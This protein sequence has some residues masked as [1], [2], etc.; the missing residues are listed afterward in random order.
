M[1]D[2]QRIAL[3]ETRTQGNDGSPLQLIR[4]QFS[5][6]LGSAILELTQNGDIISYEEYYPYG[7]TSYQ[8]VTSQIQAPRKRYR[9]TGMERD[10][11]TGFNYHGAR[12]YVLWLGR[13]ASADPA[14]LVDGVN[15]FRYARVNPIRL[16]DQ[17][18]EKPYDPGSPPDASK[19]EIEYW[20]ETARV[21]RATT[22]KN[23]DDY[24]ANS[25]DQVKYE[26]WVGGVYDY[27]SDEAQVARKQ[28]KIQEKLD[29]ADDYA[30]QAIKRASEKIDKADSPQVA[31]Q[32]FEKLLESDKTLKQLHDNATL[33]YGKAIE[34]TAQE[35][36]I[37][38][39]DTV[40]NYDYLS[41]SPD[42]DEGITQYGSI[43]LYHTSRY[44]FTDRKTLSI[45][46]SVNEVEKFVVTLVHELTHAQR[47][48]AGKAPQAFSR[49]K[50]PEELVKYAREEIIARREELRFAK[51]SGIGGNLL[52][53]IKE[54]LVRW[55]N[56]KKNAE[57]MV[58]NQYSR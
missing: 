32:K 11:E 24:V 17:D 40:I 51:R 26:V 19:D 44:L 25:D 54:G 15:L 7:S 42:Q 57:N 10:E 39:G 43:T 48:K 37:D 8:A 33:F 30:L 22:N 35:Y 21:H 56:N 28:F 4:Y 29:Q 20:E 49:S 52:K 2:Q 31:R 55:Q 41:T 18:G 5:N 50:N 38:I 13:W 16:V 6:H 23:K 1:D 3:V 14:G 27:Y 53:E 12:Y 36:N 47:Q 9:Y 58:L 45:D 34:L 46:S